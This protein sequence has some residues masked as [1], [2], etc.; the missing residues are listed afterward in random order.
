MSSIGRTAAA[1]SIR[2]AVSCAAAVLI[3]Y[4]GVVHEVVGATLYPEG[5]SEFGGPLVWHAAGLAGIAAGLLLAAGAVRVLAV[6][7]RPLAAAVG[8]IGAAVFAAE[9]LGNGGFHFFAF[10]LVVAGGFL[11]LTE[12]AGGGA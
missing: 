4:V 2:D 12:R 3:A 6:P 9:A 7:V 5:P 10:T 11:A 1:L 8:V